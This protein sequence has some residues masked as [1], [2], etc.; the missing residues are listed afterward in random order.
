MATQLG[1]EE[2]ITERIQ[3]AVQNTRRRYVLYYLTHNGG[4]ASLDELIDRIAAWENGDQPDSVAPRKRKSVYGSLHQ[5]HLP[6]LEELGLVNHDT[7]TRTVSIT[8]TGERISI[9]CAPD[10]MPKTEYPKLTLGLV[11]LLLTHVTLAQLDTVP[12]ELLVQLSSVW[13]VGLSIVTLYQLYTTRLWKRR[14]WQ[15][16]PDYIVEMEEEQQSQ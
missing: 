9:Y 1:R 11:G 4:V 15:C 8:E 5:T 6:K 14:Y 3:K 2:S 12:R 10:T 7:A 13:V 16:G